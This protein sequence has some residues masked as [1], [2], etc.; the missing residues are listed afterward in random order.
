MTNAIIGTPSSAVT[1]TL[2]APITLSGLTYNTLFS[3][4]IA[5]AASFDELK[6][7]GLFT[8]DGTVNV[9][10]LGGFVAQLGMSFNLI[11]FGSFNATGFNA[12]TDF[13]FSG[14]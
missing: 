5:G 2:D 13:N 11:N 8:L 3:Q 14:A 1:L 12:A 4:T 10:T 7:S 9:A 6:V